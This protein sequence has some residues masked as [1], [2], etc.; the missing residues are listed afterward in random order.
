MK[1]VQAKQF[2]MFKWSS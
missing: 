1:V 2:N